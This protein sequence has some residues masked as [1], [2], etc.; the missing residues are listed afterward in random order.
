MV[1]DRGIIFL[2]LDSKHYFTSEGHTISNFQGF[3]CR[4]TYKDRNKEELVC[5][6]PVYQSLSHVRLFATPW[7][8]CSPPGSSV[9]GISQQEYWS[10]LPFPPPGDR[11]YP[12]IKL[13]TPVFPI[14]AGGFFTTEPLMKPHQLDRNIRD[15]K[16]VTLHMEENSCL[17]HPYT[18]HLRQPVFKVW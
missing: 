14:L 16:N 7:T 9:C 2:L 4:N 5:H 1:L 15:Q 6:S 8:V 17:T 18:F 13:M 10:R 12:G 11:P 3:T